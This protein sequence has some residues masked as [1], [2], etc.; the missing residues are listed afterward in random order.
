MDLDANIQ[1]LL[2]IILKKWRVIVIFAVIGALLAVVYTANFTTLTY[3]SNVK[4][5]ALAVDKNQELMD[6]TTS[7]QTASNTSKMNYAIK[8]LDT[9]IE[10]LQTNKFT[11]QVAD[12]L[13][14][15]TL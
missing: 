5:L 1:K 12:E 7:A 11:Q 6:S 2:K 3:S 4:F 8:M 14:V 10:L 9:Y 13:K 15:E